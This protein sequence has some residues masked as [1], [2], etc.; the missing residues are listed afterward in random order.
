MTTV[1]EQTPVKTETPAEPSIA[2]VLYAPESVVNTDTSDVK[3][4]EPAQKQD[5]DTASAKADATPPADA[6]KQ[7]VAKTEEKVEEKP[8]PVA[9]QLKS[10]TAAARRLG[11]EK[12]D[13]E[14]QLADLKAQ[15]EE[16]LARANG[17]WKEKP[18]PSADQVAREADF[19]GREKA[20]R[21]IAEQEFGAEAVQAKIYDKDSA[22]TTLTDTKPWL[23]VEVSEHPQPPVAA[24]KILAR[25]D[26]MTKYGDDPRKWEEKILAQAEPKLFEKFKKKLEEQPVGKEVP[27][28]S[29]ARSAGGGADVKRELSTAEILY[30]GKGNG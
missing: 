28:V 15:N 21:P 20:A 13:L 5:T 25:E 11:K 1:A 9:E 7:S 19:R 23:L 30:D 18:K 27:T 26:F 2:D 8:D 17:T 14:K 4:E 16:I 24:M 22:F 29:T 6:E 10:Q 3:K 12:A